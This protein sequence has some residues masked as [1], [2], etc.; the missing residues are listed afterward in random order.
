[1]YCSKCGNQINSSANFCDACGA[2]I[3]NSAPLPHAKIIEPPL[4]LKNYGYNLDLY[5]QSDEVLLK[6]S[7]KNLIIGLIF[8][9]VSIPF[10]I[11]GGFVLTIIGLAIC[12][13]SRKY[14]KIISQRAY[15]S[16]IEESLNQLPHVDI[17]PN[18]NATKPKR[19]SLASM[20]YIDFRSIRSNTV[21]SRL[22]PLVVIDVET[23]GLNRG[24]DK[25]MSVAAIKYQ[26]NF[27]PSEVFTTLVNP[28]KPNSPEAFAVNHISDEMVATAPK[29]YQISEQFQTFIDDCNIAGY[30]TI[31]DLEF[32]YK[33]GI[34]FSEKVTYYDVCEEARHNINKNEISDYKLQTVCDYY[35]IDLVPHNSLSDAFATGKIL[36]KIVQRK[37]GSTQ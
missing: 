13:S 34:D 2:P 14:K 21:V 26:N 1:M 27:S 32:L 35:K 12:I 36:K 7:H 37:K 18:L 11:Y 33:S 19:Q 30:N 28:E 22:F 9:A 3:C 6:K 29:F 17:L 31:F 15:F 8:I 4:S 25:I 24:T 10:F 20:P 23:T 5:P 16:R